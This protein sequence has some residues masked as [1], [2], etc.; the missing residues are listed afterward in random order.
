[1][2][3]EYFEEITVTEYLKAFYSEWDWDQ[4]ERIDSR[5]F[6]FYRWLGPILEFNKHVF[7]FYIG[8]SSFVSS[9][10]ADHYGLLVHPY[11]KDSSLL[12]DLIELYNGS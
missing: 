12:F 3:A 9:N 2:A 1:M 4:L 8:G 10:I 5:F 7:D 11:L 6:A